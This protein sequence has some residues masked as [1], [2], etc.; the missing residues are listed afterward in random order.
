MW[1]LPK[2]SLEVKPRWLGLEGGQNS[3]SCEI[4]HLVSGPNEAQALDV[5]SQKEFSERQ[6]GR[7]EVDLFKEKRST[8]CGPFQKEGAVSGE[9]HA[10]EW[11][12]E[13]RKCSPEMW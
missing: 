2:P 6:S 1:T 4:I 3:L 11:T 10:T 7:E 5:S 13:E 9:T 8:V 12:M